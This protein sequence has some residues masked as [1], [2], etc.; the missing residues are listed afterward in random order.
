M[1]GSVMG[2]EM[3]TKLSHT[4]VPL[5]SQE[6]ADKVEKPLASSSLFESDISYIGGL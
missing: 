2:L 1:F 3:T 6:S 4:Y 5:I